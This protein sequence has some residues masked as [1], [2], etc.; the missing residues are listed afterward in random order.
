MALVF[1]D[2]FDAGDALIKWQNSG[3]PSSAAGGRFGSGRYLSLAGSEYVQHALSSA[4]TQAFVGVAMAAAG[5]DSS[6]RVLIQ[7][8][9]DLQSTTHL[10][11]G[12]RSGAIELRRGNH[13]GTVLGTYTGTFN[14]NTF[15]YIEASAT[16]ADSGGTC[17][18]RYNGQTVISYTGDTKNGG[19]N[20]TIDGVR[21]AGTGYATQFDDF[22][23]C[24]DTGSAPYNTF[25][26]DT[27][28]QTIVPNG[29]GASTQF[30][31]S[32]GANYTTVDELPYSATDYV[33]SSTTG[34][35][36]TYTLSDLG[37]VNTVFAVQNNV[38][39]KKTDTAA[40]S[41]KPALKSSSTVAYGST[42]ALGSSDLHMR[43]LRI[44]DPNTSTAWTQSGVNALEAGF[45]VA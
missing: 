24:D 9:S 27:R 29:A 13:V 12:I 7:F 15:Y 19:T 32:T 39:A 2:G 8:L 33:T 11:V 6:P 23:L 28:V 1:M 21:L 3:S 31:P 40:L 26:G 37:A 25:L 16:I 5:L 17:T 35:R 42:T 43:D 36:D 34:H 30:T 45:E 41:I 22:Y 20:T 14:I 44:A 4:A 10:T 38:I 18:V